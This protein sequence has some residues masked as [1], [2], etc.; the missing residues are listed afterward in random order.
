[1]A[2]TYGWF[3]VSQNK[4]QP[5]LSYVSFF[6]DVLMF[7]EKLTYDNNF[8]SIWRFGRIK[9]IQI[10]WSR[11]FLLILKDTSCR[12]VKPCFFYFSYENVSV[13][14]TNC[15]P[16]TYVRMTSKR[17]TKNMSSRRES[18]R[19]DFSQICPDNGR[20]KGY[21][22]LAWENSFSE[23]VFRSEH[24]EQYWYYF[25]HTTEVIHGTH[26]RGCVF[27]NDKGEHKNS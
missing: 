16:D 24:G 3:F 4:S 22:K 17:D 23:H 12:Y 15:M 11:R 20:Y 10:C 6:G 14:V 2:V 1:M 8:R 5:P 27:K 13:T 21:W 7:S 19:Y 26:Y 25:N 18:M 9:T